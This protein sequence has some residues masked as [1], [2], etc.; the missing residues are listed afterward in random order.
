MKQTPFTLMPRLELCASLLRPHTRVC[1]VGTDHAY[2]PV[3]LALRGQ[4]LSAL[5]CDVREGPLRTAQAHIIQ[6]GVS[7]LVRTRLSDGLAAIEPQE[8][9]DIVIAGMGGD[10]IA[11]IVTETDWLRDPGKHLILQPMTKAP[12]LRRALSNAGFALLQENAVLDSGRPYTAMSYAFAPSK[13]MLDEMHIYTGL[14]R[15]VTPASRA[16][17][18]RTRTH[19]QSRLRG[20]LCE[21]RNTEAAVLKQVCCAIESLFPYTPYEEKENERR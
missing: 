18:A 10:L 9:E 17:L 16:Y 4:I 6:Y 19:L 7:A 13:A 1:D 12:A 8:A 21:Q 11:R 15:P 14:L 2:L 5:A 3:A 20:L